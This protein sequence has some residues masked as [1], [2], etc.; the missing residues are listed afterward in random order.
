M[1]QDFE[2][3][4]YDYYFSVVDLNTNI[5]NYIQQSNQENI[6]SEINRLE[7][8]ELLQNKMFKNASIIKY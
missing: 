2:R 8:E 4:M 6:Q 1:Q 7:V 5:K 3:Y